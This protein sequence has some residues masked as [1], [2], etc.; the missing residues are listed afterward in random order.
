MQYVLQ[1]SMNSQHP[2]EYFVRCENCLSCSFS[3][4]FPEKKLESSFNERRWK[5]EL[6][7]WNGLRFEYFWRNKQRNEESKNRKCKR[8]KTGDLPFL[9]SSV[10]G[11]QRRMTFPMCYLISCSYS[12]TSGISTKQLIFGMAWYS[13][14]S[15]TWY[16]PRLIV[17]HFLQPPFTIR[18]LSHCTW[19]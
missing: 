18:T 9:M 3:Q 11:L 14:V 13:L 1:F 17:A 15:I 7:G 19:I 2:V 6:F 5:L 10:F 12:W 4:K 8:R 16:H